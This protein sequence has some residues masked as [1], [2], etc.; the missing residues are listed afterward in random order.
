MSGGKDDIELRFVFIG[1]KF[2]INFFPFALF[3]NFLYC[4]TSVLFYV[5]F[6]FIGGLKL[7]FVFEVEN[8]IINFQVNNLIGTGLGIG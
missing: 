4:D 3:C 1:T 6:K 2:D 5:F 8:F 7:E